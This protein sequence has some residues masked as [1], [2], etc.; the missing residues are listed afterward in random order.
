MRFA[1]VGNTDKPALR[2][3]VPKLL[4][5]LDST[6][7]EYVIDR[8]I[9]NLLP[10]APRSG[11]DHGC[12]FDQC[13]EKSDVLIAFGGDGTILAAARS[14]GGRG[15]PILGINLGKLGFLAEVAP[16]GMQEAIGDILNNK[17]YIEDRLVL[18]A[19]SPSI[20][21]RL[22]HAVNDIVVDKS[23]SSRVIDIEMHIDGAYAV[24]YRGDGLIVS[25]PTGS[26]AYALSNG[27]PIVT[28]ASLVIGITPISP[29]TLSGRPIIVPD[30]SSI[31]IIV[32]ADSDEVLI[33]ADGQMESF[34]RPPI[35]V[36]VKKAPYPVRL[37]KR[38]DT[39]YFDVLRAK[40]LWGR[41]PKGS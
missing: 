39:T 40:L 9:L 16:E 24:T 14:V 41:N 21:G 13:I 37:V 26:T 19:S 32:Q 27:G 35:E 10:D 2:Q 17:F 29:H 4:E 31:R 7:T 12:D 11:K 38:M 20:P 6:G 25:T 5:K 30:T 23:R 15:T 22:L 34:V 36:R 33:S 3:A 28:P 8:K 18:E 1:I